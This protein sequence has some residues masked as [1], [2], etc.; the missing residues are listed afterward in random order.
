MPDTAAE[1]PEWTTWLIEDEDGAPF[2]PAV[3]GAF[4][5]MLAE[6]VAVERERCAQVAEREATTKASTPWWARAEVCQDIAAAIRG[7]ND[8]GS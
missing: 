6:A 8:A 3:Q 4:Q 5:S 7:D 2:P 1:K